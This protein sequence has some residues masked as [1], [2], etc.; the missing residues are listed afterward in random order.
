MV[1]LLSG[2]WIHQSEPIRLTRVDSPWARSVE[3]EWTQS[4]FTL[5]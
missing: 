2:I 4:E 3:N 1:T 5:W